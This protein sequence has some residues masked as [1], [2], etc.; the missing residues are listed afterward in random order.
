MHESQTL[1]DNM[2]GLCTWDNWDIPD[3]FENYMNKFSKLDEHML[4]NLLIAFCIYNVVFL[5]KKMVIS[6]I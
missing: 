6:L 1:E 2:N 4:L 3:K 5:G